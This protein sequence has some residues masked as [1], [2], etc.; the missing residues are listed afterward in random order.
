TSGRGIAASVADVW[1]INSYIA[2][3]AGKYPSATSNAGQNIDSYGVYSDA[4]PG[5]LRINN[6]YI[7]AQ[8][9]N[10]FIGGAGMTT[11]NTATVTNPTLTSATLSNVNN[12]AVG[13]LVAFSYSS[14]TTANTG[15]PYAK[16]WQT[17]KVTSVVGNTIFFTVV[18]GQNS[19]APG[20]P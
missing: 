3:F 19:C 14:C 2:G 8:F 11:T 9:N 7:E 4:G 18:L 5:P 12:L 13:E 17:G 20:I 15:N 1:I 10:V 6:N 16:P